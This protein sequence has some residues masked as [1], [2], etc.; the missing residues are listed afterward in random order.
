MGFGTTTSSLG[1]SVAKLFPSSTSRTHVRPLAL[2][3]RQPH[4]HAGEGRVG[5]TLHNPGSKSYGCD[6]GFWK[7]MSEER[8]TSGGIERPKI[9]LHLHC[10]SHAALTRY[11]YFLHR[12]CIPPSH[13]LPPAF[14]CQKKKK[15]DIIALGFSAG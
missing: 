2:R 4:T 11:N 13:P 14:N 3:R 12:L 15:I 1:C 9:L 5:E 8:K 7:W 10:K 6:T